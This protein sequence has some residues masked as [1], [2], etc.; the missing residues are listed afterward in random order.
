MQRKKMKNKILI[1][2]ALMIGFTFSQ[3]VTTRTPASSD[4]VKLLD[5][6]T[7]EWDQTLTQIFGAGLDATFGDVTVDDVTFDQIVA[8]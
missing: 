4:F 8:D 5:S 2:M 1:I 7:E 6:N 3:K